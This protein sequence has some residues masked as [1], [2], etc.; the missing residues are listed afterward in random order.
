VS[1][2]R[3]SEWPCWGCATDDE[4]RRLGRAVLLAPSLP[5]CEA[6]LRGQTVPLSK[7]DAEQVARLGGRT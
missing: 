7:L 4:T 5:I 6:L 3:K 2:N 1:V